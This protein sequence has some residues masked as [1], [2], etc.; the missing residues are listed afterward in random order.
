MKK[1]INLYFNYTEGSAQRLN[2]FKRQG[3]DEFF[4]GMYDKL[5]TLSWKQ[6]LE[7]AN[8]LGLSCTMM[9]CSYR[10]PEL[11]YFWEDSEIGEAVCQNY[12]NQIE[13]CGEFCSNFV[14]HL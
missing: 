12:I 1:S 6:Q 5:E 9:H 11:N 10:E 4:T 3:Y 7:L 14:V 13:E 2:E 8:S